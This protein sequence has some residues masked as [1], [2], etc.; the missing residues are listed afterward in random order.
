MPCKNRPWIAV[1]ARK[2]YQYHEVRPNSEKPFFSLD[3]EVT[4]RV[5]SHIAVVCGRD[6]LSVLRRAPWS[7]A[8]GRRPKRIIMGPELGVSVVRTDSAH[9]CIGGVI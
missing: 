4:G 7:E 5:F 9:L 3:T 1:F 2:P 8:Y 6:S